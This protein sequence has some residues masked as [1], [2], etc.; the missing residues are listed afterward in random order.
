VG[1]DNCPGQ[2]TSRTTGKDPLSAFSVGMTTTTYVVLDTANMF[3]SCSFTINVTDVE[4]PNIT[5]PASAVVTT[6]PNV[7]GAVHNYAQPWFHDNCAGSSLQRFGLASGSQ[8]PLGNSSVNYT[9]T[10]V[11]G[12]A[13]SCGFKVAVVD[14][15][16]PAITCPAHITQVTGGACNVSISFADPTVTDACNVSFVWSVGGSSGDV[17]NVGE[18]IV[19]FYASDTS[20]NVASCSFSIFVI[21]SNP[22]T[23]VCPANFTANTTTGLCTSNVSFVRPVAV[24][25]CPGVQTFGPTGTGMLLP[26]G[27]HRMA[28]SSID[29]SNLTSACDL[30]VTVVDAEAPI[31]TCPGAVV[32]STD[33]QCSAAVF[34]PRAQVTDNCDSPQITYSHVNGSRFV[35]GNTTVVASTADLHGNQA[36]CSFVVTVLDLTLPAINCPV[37]PV[38]SSAV[39]FCGNNVSYVAPL[40]TD[41][42]NASTNQTG[43]QLSAYFAVGTTNQTYTV[44]DQEGQIASCIVPIVVSDVEL[45]TITCPASV[46]VNT[47]PGTCSAPATF[48]SVASTDNCAVF[49]TTL[50]A[51][52][53]NQS[54]FPFGVTT[55]TYRAIDTGRN[56]ASCSFSVTVVDP[57]VPVITCPASYWV[58]NIPLTCAAWINHTVPVGTDN[59]P[60]VVT[61]RTI[62]LG[63]NASYAV[64]SSTETYITMDHVTQVATC[65]FV[66]TVR[67]VEPPTIQCPSS[68]NI[69]LVDPGLC[70][71]SFNYTLPTFWDNCNATLTRTAGLASGSFFPVGST[72]QQFVAT[73]AAGNTARCNFTV[74]VFD[75]QMPAMTCPA[76]IALATDLNVCTKRV[77][78]NSPNTS[79]NCPIGTS[80]PHSAIGSNNTF[81]LGLTTE[82]YVIF[83]AYGNSANCSFTVTIT[84]QETPRITCPANISKANDAGVCGA[85]ITFGSVFA[86]DN[87]ANYTYNQTQGIANNSLLPVDTLSTNVFTVI[88]AVGLQASCSFAAFVSDNEAPRITCPQDITQAC[89]ANACVATVNYTLPSVADNCNTVNVT[90][91]AG[92]APLAQFPKGQTTVTYVA[93]D[94][95]GNQANCSFHVTVQDTQVPLITC[96]ASFTVNNNASVCGTRATFALPTVSDNCGAPNVTQTVGL[97]SGQLFPIGVTRV[98]FSATDAVGLTSDCSLTVTVVDVEPPL[99][100]ASNVVLQL[101]PV[102]WTNLSVAAV[103]AGTTDNCVVHNK[104]LSKTNFTCADVGTQSVTLSAT[105]IYDNSASALVQVT[106]VNLLLPTVVAQNATLSLNSVG[107]GI[108]NVSNIENGSSDVCGIAMQTLSKT[109][110]ACADVGL[111]AVVYNV[112]NVHGNWHNVTAHV[113][114]LDVTAPAVLTQDRTVQLLSDGTGSIT[115]A[116]IDNGS[117]DACG[118]QSQ[119]LSATTFSCA[120]VARNLTAQELANWQ[121]MGRGSAAGATNVVRMN[122]TDV[123][124]NVAVGYAAI[125][126]LDSVAPVAIARDLVITLNESGLVSLTAAAVDNGSTDACGVASLSINQTQFACGSVGVQTVQ[127]TVTDTFG[128]TAT[129]LSAVTVQDTTRPVN[130]LRNLTVQLNAAGQASIVATDVDLSTADACGI[131][132]RTIGNTSFTC[133]NVGV[134]RVNFTATDNNGN[135]QTSSV[136]VTVVDGVAPTLALQNAA[137]TLSA[138]GAATVTTATFDTGTTDAC[139]VS[140][141]TISQSAVTCA[142][143]GVNTLNFTATDV[144]GNVAHN[145]VVLTVTDSTA[146]T[147]RVRNVTVTLNDTGH[148]SIVANDVNNGSSDACGISQVAVSPQAFVCADSVAPQVVTLSTTDGSGNSNTSTAFV[149]VVNRGPQIIHNN[150]T[151]VLDNV[152]YAATITAADVDNSSWAPCG[153]ASVTISKTSFN[154]SDV[155]FA[156]TLLTVTDNMGVVVSR[157]VSIRVDSM[158]C[159][160]DCMVTAW[161]DNGC[162]LSCGGVGARTF[163]RSIVIHPRGGLACPALVNRTECITAACP[164]AASYGFQT[165]FVF[166]SFTGVGTRS[167]SIAG[168][169]TAAEDLMLRQNI[170]DSLGVNISRV[171][172]TSVTA[173]PSGGVSVTVTVSN[174]ATPALAA[175]GRSIV[176]GLVGLQLNSTLGTFSVRTTSLAV[177]NNNSDSSA[178]WP[179]LGIGLGV[180]ILFAVIGLVGAQYYMRRRGNYRASVVTTAPGTAVSHQTAPGKADSS[181]RLVNVLPS[182][183]RFAWGALQNQLQAR[184]QEPP[185]TT[186]GNFPRPIMIRPLNASDEPAQMP[187]R[188]AFLQ[189]MDTNAAEFRPAKPTQN[190]PIKDFPVRRLSFVPRSDTELTAATAV[191]ENEPEQ[192]SRASLSSAATGSTGLP[193]PEEIFAPRD[194]ATLQNDSADGNDFDDAADVPNIPIARPRSGGGAFKG[195]KVLPA[196]PI[197]SL[198]PK[199][200]TLSPLAAEDQLPSAQPVALPGSVDGL[201]VE[202]VEPKRTLAGAPLSFPAIPKPPQKAAFNDPFSSNPNQLPTFNLPQPPGMG[203]MRPPLPTL[204]DP[205]RPGARCMFVCRSAP[206]SCS[207]FLRLCVCVCPCLLNALLTVFFRSSSRESPCVSAAAWLGHPARVGTA[208]AAAPRRAPHLP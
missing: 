37:V 128:N 181:S 53:V 138:A 68:V 161:V 23:L 100:L 171:T 206:L 27:G 73:D 31:I 81:P 70:G 42:C 21:D 66:V 155:P 153:V 190:Q 40:G 35:Y 194:P 96:P 82:Q 174:Y 18:T 162:S 105:D 90:R 196:A 177:A 170:A 75:S 69:T 85:V 133:A 164:G 157:N 29:S 147:V 185:Q 97:A 107:S 199:G 19:T 36:S 84:D 116:Q 141:R 61:R 15:T 189:S 12:N 200:V 118:V 80:S 106:L 65:S 6:P 149:T 38:V 183:S 50:V 49:N 2:V 83:D 16:P 20:G 13:R 156:T 151:L 193:A 136:F 48:G 203:P 202:D 78:Y 113:R 175:A 64:G 99:V 91:T 44:Y 152:T 55:Q 93:I 178:M 88:D 60:G 1:V 39:G 135:A 195:N 94:P 41:N 122:V 58:P 11:S 188:P 124:G 131:A 54:T 26:L 71:A 207:A 172:I 119:S 98:N 74:M 134:G 121:T 123:N 150:L 208:A 43:G 148:V 168:N 115:T 47:L 17:F 182:P 5:C 22:P 104:S 10:D 112:T 187:L 169:W 176:D 159:S 137:V 205:Y 110:F 51:G 14:T 63:T 77:V 76:P 24:D 165:S 167:R 89:D 102:G 72:V 192:I 3:A 86:V 57:E 143:L 79:D 59:C 129:A 56:S 140:A 30:F 158:N 109:S 32:V 145:T 4:L 125:T 132:S 120:D 34:F 25:T 114:V 142:N 197:T 163:T 186:V 45:P 103:D 67:D 173:L 179:W 126:V 28:Y 144:N 201:V 8:F 204:H 33:N 92:L 146:P 87:C 127:L 46:T 139:G 62:G 166:F 95:S 160:S 9:V 101:Q 52:L 191:M 130:V 111:R 7:C 184:P 108:L 198:D 117:S 154:C 180:G